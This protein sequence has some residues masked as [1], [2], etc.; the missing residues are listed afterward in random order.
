MT[1]PR[2]RALAAMAILLANT[3][4]LLNPTPMEAQSPAQTPPVAPQRDPFVKDSE[5]N[6]SPQAAPTLARIVNLE[7]T[8]EVYALAQDDA[9]QVLELSGSGEARHT[10]V[11]ALMKEGKARLETLLSGVDKSGQ[12]SVVQSVDEVRYGTEYE[13]KPGTEPSLFFTE[14]ETRSAGDTVEFEPTLSA[15]GKLCDLNFVPQ[16]IRLLG[17]PYVYGNPQNQPALVQ[18]IFQ[19]AKI[20][21]SITV[22]TGET[23]FLGTMSRPPQFEDAEQKAPGNETRLAFGRIDSV[24]L[25]TYRDDVARPWGPPLTQANVE[26][27]LTFY[28]LDREAARQ[29]LNDGI[30]SEA[31]YNAVMALADKHEA[32]LERLTVLKTKSGQRAVVEEINEVRYPTEFG[33]TS[34]PRPSPSPGPPG[35]S[36]PG[37][38]SVSGTNAAASAKAEV[39]PWSEETR[40]TGLT[41]E[42]EPSVDP[43]GKMVDIN[44]VPNLVSD[45]G[46]L[47]GGVA[48]NETQPLFETRKIVTSFTALIGEHTLIG[49]FSDPGDDGVNGRKDTGRTWFGFIRPTL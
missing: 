28:S 6:A 37:F 46:P 40:N 8:F 27:E 49:T 18:P 22:A 41:L 32:K 30:K 3:L 19:T 16:R 20:T 11:L 38:Q 13:F 4:P 39:I 48:N 24:D 42:I 34:D 26:L 21:T 2:T 15:D 31:C 9:A 36:W 29:I 12:R 43:S 35:S 10:A 25:G 23:D 1:I 14:F 5:P 7:F 33:L 17:F 47:Q 44:L 45:E